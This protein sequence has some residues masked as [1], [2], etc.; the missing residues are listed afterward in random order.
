MVVI[1]RPKY[2]INVIL[3]YTHNRLAGGFKSLRAHFLS[4][5]PQKITGPTLTLLSHWLS[6]TAGKTLNHSVNG[7][8]PTANI[9]GPQLEGMFISIAEISWAAALFLAHSP[10]ICNRDYRVIKFEQLT[11]A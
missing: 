8:D 3:N 9:A 10:G 2:P 7:Y 6:A 1:N 5:R 11:S 4:T